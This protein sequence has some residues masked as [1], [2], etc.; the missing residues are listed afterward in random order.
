MTILA[1]IP[2]CNVLYKVISTILAN[3]LKVLFPQIISLNQSAFIH[4]RLLLE[5]VLLVTEL[6]KDYHNE[7]ISP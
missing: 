1:L 3:R 4:G 2:F 5:S 7:S 6:F